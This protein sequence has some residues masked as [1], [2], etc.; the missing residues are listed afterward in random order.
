MQMAALRTF[1]MVAQAGGFHA[2][3]ER[4]HVT[5]ATVSARIKTLEARLGERLFD[6]GRRGAT[7]TEP[8]R[9]LLPYAERIVRAWEQAEGV[10]AERGAEAVL[11]R[12]GTQLSVW[13]PLLID[14]ALWIE[15][16][17][18]G[19]ALALD[20]DYFS[21]MTDAVQAGTL[22]VVITDAAREEADLAARPLFQERIVLVSSRPGRLGAP[23]LPGTVALDWGLDYRIQYEQAGI[24]LPPR[25]IAFT[26][27]EFGM[28]Y[29]LAAG[30]T[31][32][33]PL[34]QVERHIR[35]GTLHRVDDA[36]EITV[37]TYA[38]YRT[39]AHHRRLIER[40]IEGVMGG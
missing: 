14:W 2:A 16:E 33:F 23:E 18:P 27:G 3:S 4:L 13:S 9:L 37:P 21:D 15:R 39:D 24:D 29:L 20:F 30:G 22:D 11:L 6:R 38:V 1:V 17:I 32:Y 8:G 34:R 7:L 10:V 36:P 25:K 40:T 12:L 31:G 28:R 35:R 19:I 26:S 5:Q